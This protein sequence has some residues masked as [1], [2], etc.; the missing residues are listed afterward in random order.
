[1]EENKMNL[2]TG[3]LLFVFTLPLWGSIFAYFLFIILPHWLNKNFPKA[4]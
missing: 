2:D 1:M 4:E 3:I